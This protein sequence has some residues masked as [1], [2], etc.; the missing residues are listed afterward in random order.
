M[1]AAK[2]TYRISTGFAKYVRAQFTADTP[3]GIDA[4]I[5]AKWPDADESNTRVDACWEEDN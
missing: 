2:V 4:A 1:Y 5:L 3:E